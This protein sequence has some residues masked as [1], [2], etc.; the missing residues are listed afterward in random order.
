MKRGGD[1]QVSEEQRRPQTWA[2]KI[3]PR[4]FDGIVEGWKRYEIRKMERDYRE[5]DYLV[6]QEW[7]G[8]Y[9]GRNISARITSVQRGLDVPG[10]RAGFGILSIEPQTY[11][12]GSEMGKFFYW[13]QEETNR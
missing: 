13:R 10:L 2:V 7:A 9:T 8:A 12:S 3:A 11:Y 5:G 1:K 4:W 6:L